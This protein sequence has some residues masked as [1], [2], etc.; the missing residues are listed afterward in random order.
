MRSKGTLW[1][2][3]ALAEILAPIQDDPYIDIST[4][5]NI[6]T[7]PECKKEFDRRNSSK[8]FCSAKCCKT[9]RRR[10]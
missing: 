6:D 4:S 10:K 1:Q 3:L 9:Y 8:S 5:P 2:L 7:C